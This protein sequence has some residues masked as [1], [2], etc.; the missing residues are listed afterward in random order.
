MRGH[1]ILFI[2][3]EAHFVSHFLAELRLA[4][5]PQIPVRFVDDISDALNVIESDVRS[6]D[7]VI[8]DIMMPAGDHFAAA[9]T[10]YGMRTGVMLY[11]M[12]RERA[13]TLPILIF[14]NVVDPALPSEFA[15]DGA[16]R[17]ARKSDYLPHEL[18]E[19]VQAMLPAKNRGE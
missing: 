16:C 6:V 10:H 19:A 12:I 1:V 15:H 4:F 17:Y 9:E 8:L 18:V 3:D 14:T 2:D 13:E 5:E 7:A 11:K